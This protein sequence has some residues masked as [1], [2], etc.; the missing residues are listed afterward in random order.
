MAKLEDLYVSVTGA[1]SVAAWLDREN[2][3]KLHLA[4]VQSLKA[5]IEVEKERVREYAVAGLLAGLI[6]GTAITILIINATGSWC[7]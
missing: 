6:A 7:V 1:E 4:E 2:A 3:E 5:W